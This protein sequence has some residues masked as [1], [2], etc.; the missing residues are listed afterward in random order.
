MG[1]LAKNRAR[2]LLLTSNGDVQLT[3][4]LLLKDEKAQVEQRS[5]LRPKER[6]LASMGF[7]DVARNM[8][9]LAQTGGNIEEA[10]SLLLQSAE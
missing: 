1:F 9:V 8:E 5:L 6:E 3:A 2:E 10:V 7:A 4:Q